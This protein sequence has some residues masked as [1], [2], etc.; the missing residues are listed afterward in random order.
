MKA[1]DIIK[2]V[3]KSRGITQVDLSIKMGMASQSGI[4]A[5]LNRDFKMSSF[6]ELTKVLDCEVILRDKTTG[7][8][9]QIT[10]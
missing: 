5:K 3:M 2:T 6:A 4:S 8:E 9:Y 10:E 1:S 7:I